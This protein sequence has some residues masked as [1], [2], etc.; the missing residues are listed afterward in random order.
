MSLHREI[1]IATEFCNQFE[2]RSVLCRDIVRNVVTFFLMFFR[3][4]V[5]T[6]KKIF[7]TK[8]FPLISESKVD[9]VAT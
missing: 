3:T 1:I 5:A 9:Y 2:V 4:Y 6:I 7:V 8:N